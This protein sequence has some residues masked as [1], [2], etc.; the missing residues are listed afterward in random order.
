MEA[1]TNQRLFK[2]NH[3]KIMCIFCEIVNTPSNTE[4]FPENVIIDETEHFYVKAALGQF[5]DGYVL[6]NSKKHLPNYS[7][8]E[9]INQFNELESLISKTKCNLSKILDINEFLI[10]EH[11]SINKL[12]FNTG[13]NAKCIDHA[14]LHIIPTQIDILQQLQSQ[15]SYIQLKSHLEVQDFR[16]KS[17]I[18]YQSSRS[19][20]KHIFNVTN[21]IPSQFVR[22]LI[23]KKLE[24]PDNWNWSLYPYREKIKDFNSIYMK[25]S[26]KMRQAIKGLPHS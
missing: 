2:T 18:Y 5:I 19:K 3:W 8:L 14:H 20:S 26:E 21:F 9:S 11:G 10:F 25:H 6:I 16:T 1:A 7:F 22:Q 4:E 15:F 24:M 13:C 23:C 12:C 17:Y